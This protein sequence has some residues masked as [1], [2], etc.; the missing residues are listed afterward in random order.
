MSIWL[1]YLF[2]LFFQF[3]VARQC[4]TVKSDLSKARVATFSYNLIKPTR[5][6]SR[7]NF[8]STQNLVDRFFRNCY[9]VCVLSLKFK[10][11]TPT[12]TYVSAREV[13]IRV[14]KKT[15]MP[16]VTNNHDQKELRQCFTLPP[17]SYKPNHL[18]CTVV[19]KWWLK[20]TLALYLKE[21]Q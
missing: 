19:F 18:S 12:E 21:C 5:Q 4:T 3:V 16:T 8:L 11:R 15:R 2:V 13:G 6:S 10:T 7:E 9:L 20:L 14:L 17:A 1:I